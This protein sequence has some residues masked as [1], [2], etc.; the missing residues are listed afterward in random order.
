MLFPHIYP[1][2][3]SSP[4][5]NYKFQIFS[6]NK[7]YPLLPL[8]LGKN[9]WRNS[10]GQLML[11]L[12][13]PL[14][15]LFRTLLP[16]SKPLSQRPAFVKCP[17]LLSADTKITNSNEA[18]CYFGRMWSLAQ[19]FNLSFGSE[20]KFHSHTKHLRIYTFRKTWFPWRTGIFLSEPKKYYIY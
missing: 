5:I 10:Y 1:P 18:H 7:F 11:E 19:N 3:L 6:T 16:S 9:V 17:G 20:F 15:R 8:D 13:S 12:H 2:Q 4:Q 14:K